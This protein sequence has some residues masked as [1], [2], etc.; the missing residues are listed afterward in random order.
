MGLYIHCS[1]LI[2]AYERVSCLTFT[3]LR[4]N[5][6]DNILMIFFFQKTKFEISCIPFFFDCATG[7]CNCYFYKH[8]MKYYRGESYYHTTSVTLRELD[9]LIATLIELKAHHKNMPI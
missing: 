9:F 2:S 7:M 6:T 3:A 1:K 4:A 5:S 8:L